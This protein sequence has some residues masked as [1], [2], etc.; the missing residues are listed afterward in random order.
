MALL[1][2]VAD[3][4]FPPACQL[5]RQ[6]GRF[7]LCP[8][9][10]GQFR[11]IVPPVCQR[12]G[13]PLRGPPGL[14]A[15]CLSCRYWWYH[16]ASARAAGVYDGSLRDAIHALKFRGCRAMAAPLGALMAQVAWWEVPPAGAL[17]PVPLH[18]RRLRERGFNQSELLARAIGRVLRI[19]VL[20]ALRRIRSTEAQSRLTVEARRE[21]V[22]GAF[23]A[24]GSLGGQAVVLVD[25]VVS[26]GFTASECARQLRRA[27]ARE[28]HLLTAAMALPDAVSGEGAIAWGPA[29]LGRRPSAPR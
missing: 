24:R 2:A 14:V 27:G 25:D 22:R 13:R 18:A 7:P 23:Q 17:V 11:L 9:C 4:L 28:V 21:N 26:T 16:Y 6:V 19:P 5:C 1:R 12:C 20:P 10:Q 15:T 3:L 29:V 8:P